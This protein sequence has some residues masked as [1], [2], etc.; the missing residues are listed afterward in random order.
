MAQQ[1]KAKILPGGLRGFLAVRVTDEKV[2]GRLQL[3]LIAQ[4]RL[5]RI[6]SVLTE[7]QQLSPGKRWAQTCQQPD[8]KGKPKYLAS[9]SAIAE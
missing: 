3:P 4:A 5:W 6:G 9:S 7:Y 2:R 8:T 1:R